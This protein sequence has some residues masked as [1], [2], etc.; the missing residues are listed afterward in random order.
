MTEETITATVDQY[1]DYIST[2]DV[3]ELTAFDPI[4]DVRSELQGNQAG[5][6][7]DTITRE[8]LVGGSN[9][10]LAPKVAVADGVTTETAVTARH[11]LDAT[12]KVTPKLITR[13]AT[14]LKRENVPKIDGSYIAIM[15]PD[16]TQDLLND[17]NF[18]KAIQ[19]GRPE[20][21]Y[22][23]EIGK[24][25]GV[26]VV[27]TSEAKIFWGA[28]LTEGSRNLTVKTAITSPAAAEIEVKEAITTAEATAMVGREIILDGEKYEVVSATAGA[29]GAAK[30][31]IDTAISIAADK[32]LY[33]GEGA[34]AGVAAYATLV[35]GA[36]AYGTTDVEG[37]GLQFIVKPK[38]YADALDLRSA[39]GWKCLFVAERLDETRI[40][41][42]EHCTAMSDIAEAN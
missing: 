6:T 34:A 35:L 28:D 15:H 25:A 23:G 21:L 42:L 26:R 7:M 16:T 29:A 18:V 27:E 2:S 4:L 24:Y 30:V 8:V 3:L 10:V 41:R 22:E 20:D 9:T 38:G 19:Y 14:L 31:E 11:L 13:A 1:G 17:A 37:G 36:G 12:A 40:V 39:S 32:V 33:P 5:L